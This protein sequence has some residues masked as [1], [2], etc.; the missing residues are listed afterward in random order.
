MNQRNLLHKNISYF[1]RYHRLIALAVLI[2]IAV[3]A[4]SLV[5]GDSVRTTLVNRVNERLGDT[6]T[7]VFSRNSFMSERLLNTALFR[8]S[9][10]G[11][12]LVNGF[13]SYKG[14]LLPVFVWGVSDMGISRGMAKINTPLAK[15]ITP[16]AQADIILRLPATGLVPSGSLFVTDNYTT[17]MRLSFDGIVNAAHGGN[18][19]MKNEQVLPLNIFVN[20][21]ELAEGMEAEGKINLLLANKH[22]SALDF[23]HVWDC[24][25]SGLSVNQKDGFTEIVS[26]RVFIQEDVVSYVT[27]HN[28]EPNRLFSYL[29]NAIELNSRS[30]PY[31]FVTAID[32]Y[33][34][35]RLLSDET[36]LSDYSA[37]RLKAKVGDEVE[38]S[39]YTSQELKTL[40][41][42]SRKLKVKKIVPLSELQADTSLSADFPGLSDVE[43]C[44]DWDSDLPINMDLITGEDERY[45]ESH[46][47]TP[48][49]IIAYE[50]ISEDWGNAYG[51]ATSIRIADTNPDLAGLTPSMFGVQLVHP[52]E[53]GIYAAKNGVDFSSL[54]LALGFFIVISAMLL[55]Q[56]PLSEMLF[57]RRNEI[58]LLKALGFPRKRIR[59]MLWAES[60]PVVLVS[61]V[62]GVVA[63]LL[64]TSV[65]LWLLGTVWKG[66]THTDGFSVYP[67][68]I[69]LILGLLVGTGLSLLLLR[70]L[71]ANS[72]KERKTD[73]R[74]KRLPLRGRRIVAV[75]SSV[76]S[77][78][79]IGANFIYLQSVIL[80]IL[81]GL[82]LIGTAALWGDYLI[83]SKGAVSVNEFPSDKLI[84]R[85]LYANKRQAVLS[86]LT[87]SI[88]VFIVFSVGLNRR[89]FA[90]SSQVKT[91]TG[92]YSLWVESTVPIYHNMM[93]KEGRGKLS[94]DGL[95]AETGI[96]QCLRYSADDASC[97]NLNK[98]STPTVLG[99]DI[100]ALI[101]SD[102]QITKSLN[103]GSLEQF[104]MQTDS[105]IPALVDATVLT[106]GL[107]M[108]L[109]DTLRYEDG[110]G[111]TISIR[112]TGT[113][114]NS[115]FQ[116]NILI[117]CNLF[118]EIWPEITGSEV[119]LLKV[120]EAEKESVKNLVSQ[121]LHEYGVTAT[122]TNDRLKQFNT[123][124]DT[125]LTIFLT[126]GGLGLLLGVM[127][128]IIVV[129]KSLAMRRNEIE[130]Y[131]TLGFPKDKIIKILYQEN[132][133]VPLYAIITGVAGSL[134]SIGLSFMNTGIGIWL[135]ALFFMLFFVV[136][137]IVFVRKSVY[138]EVMN[139]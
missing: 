17:S 40:L 70:R 92:G 135:I 51:N 105:V 47:S 116:G 55:M 88:G 32:S 121:A 9:G 96:L 67:N 36:I 48:K 63:G 71:I 53:A 49:A 80:F 117:D 25:S 66:A 3:I 42:K 74:E 103:E 84:W 119:F 4:G 64:Y 27:K 45:W 104:S 22:I 79:I 58:S 128:F 69:T 115:I 18:I 102:F 57:T 123:V 125:Y 26:D 12:L 127:S 129:G 43:R 8:E 111:R 89:G 23:S 68:I 87:L 108:N 120:K 94:L 138:T 14:K 20:R 81:V 44:T 5:V 131:G 11:I 52:R 73:I 78:A 110:N 130:L 133:L 38:I 83:C 114:S 106:W 126:L 95:P 122:T 10:R 56:I 118:K 33:K 54:F 85:T 15:E 136:C 134:A 24:K 65:I 37:E 29:A 7:I 101:D 16:E 46:R 2:T 60:A 109:G 61:S 13:I 50:A 139:K 34:G 98:V 1:I 91:G 93:T 35:E 62:A 137:V 100:N 99:V 39:Y 6:E 72:L 76:L 90:D 75:F 124:T 113:L 28:N 132:I 30:I 41:E 19:S 59:Q 21:H 86:F 97:L 82:L 77:V 112:L 107:M 31:S